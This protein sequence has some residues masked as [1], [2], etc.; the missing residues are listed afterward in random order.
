MRDTAAFQTWK[1][2]RDQIIRDRALLDMIRVDIVLKDFLCPITG[3]LPLYP[4]RRNNGSDMEQTFDYEPLLEY[5]Q[6]HP[7]T[8]Y[9]RG[10]PAFQLVEYEVEGKMIKDIEG[11]EFDTPHLN[12]MIERLG[13]INTKLSEITATAR[14]QF[15]QFNK[16]IRDQ[17]LK[18]REKTTGT[19]AKKR[20][21]DMIDQHEQDKKLKDES[22]ICEQ[23]TKGEKETPESF[24]Y[25]NPQS[26]DTLKSYETPC[27][28]LLY[29][30]N[31]FN[32]NPGKRSITFVKTYNLSTK[33][34]SIRK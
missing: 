27:A 17:M 12:T 7:G 25:Y 2:A 21:D 20:T 15:I 10:E 23:D 8:G 22:S 5:V 11:L 19:F 3:K 26:L 24:S 28:C 16:Q 34:L 29:V 30:R 13:K 31:K 14:H 6:E 1:I 9:Y 18:V 32:L 33:Y 4:V